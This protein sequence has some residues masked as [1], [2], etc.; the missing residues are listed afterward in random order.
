MPKTMIEAIVK[1]YTEKG[2]QINSKIE[3]QYYY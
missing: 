1:F 2:P 3:D